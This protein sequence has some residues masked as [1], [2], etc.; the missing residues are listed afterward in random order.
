MFIVAGSVVT[1]SEGNVI[2]N[3]EY[4]YCAKKLGYGVLCYAI[5]KEDITEFFKYM[6]LE[7]GEYNFDNLNIK[8][9]HQFLAQ[10]GRLS[11][12]GRATF[13][14]VLYEEH[15]I[16]RL[17]KTDRIIDIGAGRMSY[18]KLLRSKGYN[19]Q[20]YEP[21]LVTRSGMKLDMKNIVANILLAEKD[22]KKNGLF[23]WCVLDAVINSVVDDEFEK[24]VLVA[25]NAVL[26]S[27]GILVTATRNIRQCEHEYDRTHL[28]VGTTYP[29]YPLDKNNY[30]IGMVGS[31]LLKQKFHTPKSYREL[32]KKYFERVYV[33][34]DTAKFIYCACMEPKQLPFET[35]EFYLDKE[36]NIEYP[37]GYKHNKHRGL[38]DILKSKVVERYGGT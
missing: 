13:K 16:P 30:T 9:Y 15:L 12:D 1:D 11:S 21:A 33:I 18:V 6:N 5:A 22:V 37:N 7:Y 38:V 2:L 34:S 17:K 4:A 27:T 23:D 24:A 32:L 28:T 8:T 36:F 19:V 10:P 26:K 3:S 25:C 20:A 31:T 29:M 35:Y 14:S